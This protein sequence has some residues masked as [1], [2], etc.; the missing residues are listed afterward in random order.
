MIQPNLFKK[1]CIF[2]QVKIYTSIH[3]SPS[4]SF[5]L[6]S[7]ILVEILFKQTSQPCLPAIKCALGTERKSLSYTNK[8]VSQLPND[9]CN[10]CSND[11]VTISTANNQAKLTNP[12]HRHRLIRSFKLH[13]LQKERVTKFRYFVS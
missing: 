10:G 6:Y 4:A 3:S 2:I 12:N 11:V 9:I 5:L 8:Y 13:L 1:I 7:L